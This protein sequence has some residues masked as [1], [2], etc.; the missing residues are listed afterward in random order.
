MLVI[1]KIYCSPNIAEFIFLDEG[2]AG[3]HRIF[4]VYN[5][6]FGFLLRILKS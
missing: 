4:F 3:I 1:D 5:I 2:N 6:I